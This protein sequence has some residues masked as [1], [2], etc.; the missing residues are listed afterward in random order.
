MKKFVLM[1]GFICFLTGM[2][3]SALN[4]E[5]KSS[6][7]VLVNGTRIDTNYISQITF[8]DSNDTTSITFLDGK[9][10]TFRTDY[11]EYQLIQQACY[12]AESSS[13]NSYDTYTT[14]PS[15]Y[16]RSWEPY[17]GIYYVNN[18][19][20]CSNNNGHTRNNNG[21]TSAHS[22]TNS[23]SS[24]TTI[25]ANA[26]VMPSNSTNN[27]NGQLRFERQPVSLFH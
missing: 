26:A 14:P 5:T 10:T 12:P 22:G 24:S 6:H 4:I 16:Y 27:S 18:H 19:N 2:S 11:N 13:S 3:A 20:N 15:V 21:H 17:G 23:G 9:I 25:P 8:N 7:V 1:M